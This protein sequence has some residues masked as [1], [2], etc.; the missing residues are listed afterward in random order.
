[1]ATTT[2]DHFEFFGYRLACSNGMTVRASLSFANG[3]PRIVDRL[4]AKVGD[5]VDVRLEEVH[6]G[7][8]T[9]SEPVRAYIRHYGKN[10]RLNLTRL[11]S[12]ILGLQHIIPEI[13]R[14]I[15]EARKSEL[16]DRRSAELLL[17]GLG[18]GDRQADAI[19]GAYSLEPQNE[20]GLY[21]AIT[22]VATHEKNKSLR[23]MERMLKMA[24]PILV[25]A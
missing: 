18:F 16:Q 8:K 25:R 4:N 6:A 15:V 3:E 13:E 23:T 10:A 21:N 17:E 19:M 24:Q 14:E 9:V 7:E 12:A 5:L 20:W 1:M 22:G 2:N 11:E